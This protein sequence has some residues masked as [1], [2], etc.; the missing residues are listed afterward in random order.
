LIEPGKFF[1]FK[2]APMT[3][4]LIFSGMIMLSYLFF[5]EWRVNLWAQAAEYVPL[6]VVLLLPLLISLRTSRAERGDPEWNEAKP[7]GPRE[8]ERREAI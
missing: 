4:W 6:Y 7:K 5:V 2:F 1:G 3:A 8:V